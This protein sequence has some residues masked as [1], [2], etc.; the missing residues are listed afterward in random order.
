MNF[1]YL[2]YEFITSFE[3]LQSLSKMKDT[4]LLDKLMK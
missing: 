2:G 3:S 4:L 1:C